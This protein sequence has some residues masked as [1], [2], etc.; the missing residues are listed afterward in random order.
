MILDDSTPFSYQK[1]FDLD[2]NPFCVWKCQMSI[3]RHGS[4]RK[5]LFLWYVVYQHTY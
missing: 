4:W 1:R 5:N 3:L 2:E